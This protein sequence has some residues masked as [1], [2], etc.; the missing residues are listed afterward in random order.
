MV[1]KRVQFD[2][3]TWEAIEAVADRTRMDFQELAK[4]AFADLLKKHKQPVGLKASRA[5]T[6]RVALACAI[7]ARF[8]AREGR[9][10]STG[11][12][13]WQR[14]CRLAWRMSCYRD[15]GGR[16]LRSLFWL[17][18]PVAHL[19]RGFFLRTPRPIL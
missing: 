14:K 3:D 7:A 8:E 12:A 4:E 15:R 1:G 5:M 9:S 17:G 10:S 13:L 11:A 18:A 16:S 2:A 19:G 6:D